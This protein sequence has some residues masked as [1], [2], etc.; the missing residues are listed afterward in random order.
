MHATLQARLR[1]LAATLTAT[2]SSMEDCTAR[3]SELNGELYGASLAL[4]EQLQ[5]M[6]NRAAALQEAAAA[7]ADE[8]AAAH[9]ELGDVRSEL[10]KVRREAAAQEAKLCEENA[11]LEAQLARQVAATEAAEIEASEA[12]QELL[13]LQGKVRI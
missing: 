2:Q 7:T 6:C 1:H 3:G 13:V 11:T 5:R 10:D 8:L 12:G 4:S 9:A